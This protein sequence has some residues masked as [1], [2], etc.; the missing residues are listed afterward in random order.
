MLTFFERRVDPYPAGDPETPPVGF[1]AFLWA[2][3]QGMRPL[4]LG[5]TVCT[6]CIGVFE[7]LLFAWAT[8]WIG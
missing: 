3:T 8:S 7:A 2:A 6:A 1:G 5:M 4:I